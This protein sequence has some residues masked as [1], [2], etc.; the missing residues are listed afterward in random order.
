M[1]G[2]PLGEPDGSRLSDND[3]PAKPVRAQSQTRLRTVEASAAIRDEQA[4]SI[5]YQHTVLCQTCLPYRN[6]SDDVRVWDRENGRVAL[7]V[8]AG[9]ARHPEDGWIEVGLPYGPKPRL[10]LGYLNTQAIIRQSPAIEV[11]DTLTA[12]VR[13]I[14]LDTHGRN[15]R[16]RKS[17][18]LN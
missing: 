7:R 9:E 11:E 3:L 5:V 2:D 17:T 13:R 18:R 8:R 10:I 15:L 16:D 12:F 1:S 4:R 14:G 6:P